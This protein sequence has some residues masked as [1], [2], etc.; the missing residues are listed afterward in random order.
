M[1]KELFEGHFYGT[2]HAVSDRLLQLDEKTRNG[3]F[4]L[5]DQ[6]ACR[7]CRYVCRGDE[8]NREQ[9][10]VRS[11]S[12]ASIMSIE[13]VF[14]F[15]RE[16]VGD[17]CDYMLES[18]DVTTLIEMTCS[19]S[20]YVKDKRQKARGQL[21][22]TLSLLY[23]NPVVREHLETRALRYVV[24]SWKKT[25]VPGD[26]IDS[27]ERNMMDMTRINDSVYSPDNESKFEFG[28]KL[29]E[30]RYPDFLVLS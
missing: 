27:V 1:L 26:E 14:S 28:Y 25:F 24:F 12:P 8:N 16:E 15:V 22:N 6:K 29:K 4:T 10:K 11:T 18:G 13:Q 21:Y 3:D 19:T 30:I 17:I 7:D 2:F 20:G 23:T 5:I 9:L